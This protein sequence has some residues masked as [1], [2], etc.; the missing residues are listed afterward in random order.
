MNELNICHQGIIK[1]IKEHTLFVEI[2]RKSACAAC[3]AKSVCSFDKK[4]E[5]ISVITNEPEKYQVNEWVQLT[6]KKSLGAKAVVLGY[7]F[8]F[9]VLALSLFITY[10]LSRN[11][12]LSVG[13]SFSATAL[14]SLFLKKMDKRF[15]KNFSFMVS[16]I[17][18]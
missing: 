7:L 11:E 9:L 5:L 15:K 12:L 16:K 3:H 4:D 13:V 17:N 8:P 1:E 18:Q 14:Y 2:E 10:Y 6:L